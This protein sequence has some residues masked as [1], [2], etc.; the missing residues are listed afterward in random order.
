MAA[1]VSCPVD[2]FERLGEDDY[3]EVSLTALLN[4]RCPPHVRVR[5]MI[6]DDY[7]NHDAIG[8]VLASNLSEQVRLDPS[9]WR[10]AATV[11]R[12]GGAGLAA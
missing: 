4:P 5:A 2:V 11:R 12:L 10:L 7:N 6:Y 9:R 3:E 1:S 8:A